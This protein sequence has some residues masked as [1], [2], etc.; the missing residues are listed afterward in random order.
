MP[1]KIFEEEGSTGLPRLSLTLG[2]FRKAFQILVRYY[3]N[4]PRV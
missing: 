4:P 2:G 1:M 3:P